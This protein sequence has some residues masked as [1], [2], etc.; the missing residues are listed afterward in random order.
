MTR[1]FDSPW[2]ETLENYLPD[3]F[4]ILFPQWHPTFDWAAGF[5]S[6]DTELR[7]LLP[8]SDA[9][10]VRAD[11][12]F[13]VGSLISPT[14]PAV[15]FV[16]FE[17]Q[18]QRD[19][20]LPER[21]FDYYCRF[22]QKYGKNVCSFAILA[23]D[24][25]R[26]R[27]EPFDLSICGT[28]SYFEFNLVK[29]LDYAERLDELTTHRSPVGL[30]VAASIRSLL[31][32]GNADLRFADKA[33]LIRQLFNRKLPD[34]E[35]WGIMR[36]LDWLLKLPDE[37]REEFNELRIELFQENQ[38]PF[39]TSFEEIAME[40]GIKEGIKLGEERGLKKGEERGQRIGQ[41]QLLEEMMELPRTSIDELQQKSLEELDLLISELKTKVIR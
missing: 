14:E 33:R 24:D 32:H 12:L 9:G 30:V 28:R 11:A 23:D 17:V 36:L 35:V 15:L 38:M 18:A 4:E 5:R 3:I 27:S 13:E 20:Q 10:M 21:M 41:I 26:W 22:R 7:T 29:L 8:D 37:L 2:K 16:H 34:Q 19:P 31:T 25:P 39:V 6:L 1:E 40:K